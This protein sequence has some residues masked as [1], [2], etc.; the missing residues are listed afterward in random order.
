MKKIAQSAR[1]WDGG[2]QAS[3][4]DK[5]EYFL[6]LSKRPE[7]VWGPYYLLGIMYFNSLGT[8]RLGRKP[9]NSHVTSAE[10]MMLSTMVPLVLPFQLNEQQ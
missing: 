8:N 10:V 7:W 3:K 6:S 5:G 9:N 1:Q 4:S 2:F